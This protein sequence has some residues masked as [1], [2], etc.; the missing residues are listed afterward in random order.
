MTTSKYENLLSDLNTLE[1]QINVLKD[2]Y[3]SIIGRNKELDV[4]LEKT[5]QDNTGLYQKISALEEEINYLKSEAEQSLSL[6]SLTTEE[7]E[8]LKKRL[9]E[10]IGRINYHLSA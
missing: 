4:A 1:T 3:S 7:R 10:L 5:K 8:S 6:G 2:K 9:Q